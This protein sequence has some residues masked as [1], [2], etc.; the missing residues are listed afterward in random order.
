[1]GGPESCICIEPTSLSCKLDA[2]G[3]YQVMQNKSDLITYQEGTCDATARLECGTRGLV[4]AIMP[5]SLYLTI[6][7]EQAGNQK[8]YFENMVVFT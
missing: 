2:V 5:V 7:S 6:Y 3:A 1:M 8:N 4:A